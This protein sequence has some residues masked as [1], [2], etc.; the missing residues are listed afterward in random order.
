MSKCAICGTNGILKS[1]I[2]ETGLMDYTQNPIIIENLKVNYCPN[3]ECN[4]TWMAQAESDR[5]DE[6]IAKKQKIPLKKS[7]IN[8]ILQALD[9]PTKTSAA[10]FLNLN[11]K[12][13][14]KW[15]NGSSDLSASNDLLLRLA[16]Y[17]KQNFDFIKHLHDTNFRFD[18]QDYELICDKFGGSW[19]FQ[20][21]EFQIAS[22]N[23]PKGSQ[24]TDNAYRKFSKDKLS[25]V[26]NNSNEE[27]A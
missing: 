7:E 5:I 20:N 27:A 4:N 14:T 13:F 16:V 23:Y 19:K 15:A 6:E 18:G 22:K 21:I 1:E 24:K 11:S 10:N 9:F 25:V 8:T 2:L 12:A 17:S 3:S 26:D